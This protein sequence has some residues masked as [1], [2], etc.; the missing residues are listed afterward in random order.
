[1]ICV[2]RVSRDEIV[3]SGFDPEW[4]FNG[5]KERICSPIEVLVLFT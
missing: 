5:E 3:F 2:R 4:E 1:V